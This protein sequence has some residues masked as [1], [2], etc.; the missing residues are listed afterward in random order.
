[1]FK[2]KLTLASILVAMSFSAVAADAPKTAP[3][4]E[5]TKEFIED[6]SYAIGYLTGQHLLRSVESQKELFQYDAEE[7]L[8]GIEDAVNKKDKFT[9]E[10]LQEKL[11]KLE[12]YL[13]A[14]Q[15]ERLEKQKAM[16]KA[17]GEKLQKSFAKQKGVKKTKSG[18]LYKII[19]KGKGISPTPED[20]VT[21]HY[22]G[23]L[24]NGMVFDS[25]YERGQPVTFKLK[26]LIPGWIEAIPMLK[27]GGKM[28]I[29]LPPSL[30]YGDQQAGSIPAGSTLKFEI[31]LLDVTKAKAPEASKKMETKEA[32]MSK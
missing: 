30:G 3:M 31:E 14:K 17:E 18:L 2:S 26:N 29:V 27:K 32:K 6:S 8:N 22:K 24:P 20:E 9:Q 19:N 13:Q 23:T 4:K 11:K 25:S 5:P 28:E 16:V 1:M 10:E 12:E 7:L 15:T 21:V